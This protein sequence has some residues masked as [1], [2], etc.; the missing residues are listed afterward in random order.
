MAKGFQHEF[1]GYVRSVKANNDKHGDEDKLAVDMS[2]RVMLDTG[3]EWDQMFPDLLG[4][5]AKHAEDMLLALKKLDF[6]REFEDHVVELS[7]DAERII[8]L[9]DVKLSKFSMPSQDIGITFNV[10][11]PAEGP[12]IGILS[13]LLNQSVRVK[14]MGRQIEMASMSDVPL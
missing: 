2:L 8:T 3:D 10:H 6:S 5:L 9:H 1:T 14:T 7:T 12:E 13:E 4:K 11:A